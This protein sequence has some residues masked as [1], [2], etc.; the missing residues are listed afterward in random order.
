MRLKQEQAALLIRCAYK[1]YQRSEAG[2]D[3]RLS[4]L[5]KTARALGADPTELIKPGE[6]PETEGKL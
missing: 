4:T 2:K 1:Y 5:P 3:I 6:L